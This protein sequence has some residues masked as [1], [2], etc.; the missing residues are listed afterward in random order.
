MP[1]G[2][3]LPCRSGEEQAWVHEKIAVVILLVEQAEQACMPA[4][5]WKAAAEKEALSEAD[6]T[7]LPERAKAAALKAAEKVPR[8]ASE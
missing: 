7:E 1:L 3:E 2:H 6:A 5:L 8:L 4:S